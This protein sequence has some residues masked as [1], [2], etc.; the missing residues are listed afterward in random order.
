MDKPQDS[1][2]L[3]VTFPSDTN[4]PAY[5]TEQLYHLLHK[6]AQPRNYLALY[7]KRK[8]T[9]SLEVVS[10]KERGIRYLIVV[11]TDTK[12]ILKRNLISYLPGVT[13]KEVTDYLPSHPGLTQRQKPTTEYC[14]NVTIE[15]LKFSHHF[16]LPLAEQKTLSVT[17]PSAYLSGN[18]TNPSEGEIV[19]YQLVVTPV[20]PKM[21]KEV[22]R[23]IIKLQQ[24]IFLVN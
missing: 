21:Q 8:V 23:S 5:A 18:M 6:L 15:E 24:K 3:E 10:S 13:I 14:R 11:P 7:V 9:Y 17:D 16:A 1:T 22:G 20:I 19:A 4:K 2:F 12:E